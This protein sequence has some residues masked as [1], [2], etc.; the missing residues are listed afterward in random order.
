MG[1]C[2]LNSMRLQTR[3]P[4]AEKIGQ[5]SFSRTCVEIPGLAWKYPDSRR[6]FRNL[7]KIFRDV[8]ISV[9]E[10]CLVY[11]FI[12]IAYSYLHYVVVLCFQLDPC[13]I[14]SHGRLT[15]ALEKEEWA[16]RKEKLLWSLLRICERPKGCASHRGMSLY[17]IISHHIISRESSI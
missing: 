2:G 6:N 1:S 8:E 5:R 12:L 9:S 14:A 17:H 16:L 10:V 3:R 4:E 7:L 15:S 13:C 11:V